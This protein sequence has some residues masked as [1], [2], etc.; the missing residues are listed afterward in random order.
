MYRWVVTSFRAGW[1]ASVLLTA[2]VLILFQSVAAAAEGFRIAHPYAPGSSFDKW[3]NDF[4]AK[5]MNAKI[6]MQPEIIHGGQLG[7]PFELLDSLRHGAIDIVLLPADI[8]ATE[9]SSFRVLSL[10]TLFPD[11][12]SIERQFEHKELLN[13]LKDDAYRYG[14]VP[15]SYGWLFRGIA[16]TSHAIWLPQDL[17]DTKAIVTSKADSTLMAGAGAHIVSLPTNEI[18]PAM[19]RG[20]ADTVLTTR[21]G[22]ESLIDKLKLAGITL[23]ISSTAFVLVIHRDDWDRL[24]S[25]QQQ[26]L[27]QAGEEAG[28]AFM[29]DEQALEKEM[30][31]IAEQRDVQ[32]T[33]LTESNDLQAWRE[34]AD[35]VLWT[36]F[37]AEVKNGKQLLE[38]ALSAP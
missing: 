27:L 28:R 38:A 1:S 31:A 17:R 2:L 22:W 16:S 12:A 7:T 10:P 9:V 19:E 4:A 20:L 5:A 23:G 14:F 11:L 25:T 33:R 30:T 26:L 15:L 29:Q 21:Y 18:F 36:D 35:K 37:K 6:D 34:I 32:V 13:I 3:V 8:I 24:D